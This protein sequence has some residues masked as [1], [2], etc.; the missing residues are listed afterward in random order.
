[1]ML[2]CQVVIGFT[3]VWAGGRIGP[4]VQASIGLIAQC[5][6]MLMALCI[7]TSNGAVAA[8][9]QSLGAKRF[10]R[11]QRYV[12]LVLYGAC[13]LALLL[14]LLGIAVRRPFLHLVQTPEAILPVALMFLQVTLLTLPAHYVLNIGAAV[15]RASKSVLRPLYVTGGVCLCNIFGDLAFGLGWWGF[16]AYGA[17][18]IAWSTFVSVCLG[19]LA[20]LGLLVRDKLL[21]RQSFPRLRWVK[22][23][24]LYLVK[25]AGPALGTSVLWNTGY[26]V[27]Y[28]ITGS[29]P[30]GSVNALA[31]LTAGLRIEAFLFMPAVGFSMTASVLVG[32]A[33]GAGQRTEAKRVIF[34]VLGIGC[35]CMGLVAFGLW[36]L[37]HSLAAILA[38][39][40]LVQAE[41]ASYLSFNILSVPFTVTSV[42]LAGALNGAGATVYPM[43]VYS[44]T[45]WGVRLPLAWWLGHHLW[46]SA[47]GIYAA[48]LISQM[49]QSSALLLIVLRCNW[50][51]F[52]MRCARA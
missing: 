29:L 42:V 26:L 35:L 20:L 11:A 32:H 48:M 27:L 36:P 23:G 22:A 49:V 44:A 33:L 13:G 6:M 19:A 43:V 41:A 12:G 50:T 40:P 18:G 21:T 46:D 4:E 3:D 37:R 8:V 25:V 28:M 31:G 51:R 14:A 16:P 38:P 24:A 47:D 15:F 1:M 39:D 34:T 5:Q 10:D 7:A 9:S 45:I 30:H 52:A 17:Q 2:L